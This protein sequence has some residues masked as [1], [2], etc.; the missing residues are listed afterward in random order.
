[1][2]AADAGD[3][4]TRTSEPT[5][6][7]AH[8]A[9]LARDAALVRAYRDGRHGAAVSS[10]PDVPPEQAAR[11]ILSGLRNDPGWADQVPS[12]DDVVAGLTALF[13]GWQD[14]LDPRLRSLVEQIEAALPVA[15][16]GPPAG[17][18]VVATLR[19]T[20]FFFAR[21]LE[22]PEIEHAYLVVM[23]ERF[24]HYTDLISR[25]V[26]STVPADILYRSYDPDEV[27]DFVRARV[28]ASPDRTVGAFADAALSLALN[29]NDVRARMLPV[30][31]DRRIMT[32]FLWDAVDLFVLGH[33]CAH[34]ELSHYGPLRPALAR[35]GAKHTRDRFWQE[36]QA[37]ELGLSL[38]AWSLRTS[39]A[40]GTGVSSLGAWMYFAAWEGF[41]LSAAILAAGT[42]AGG[43]R[44]L[45]R[46]RAVQDL[47]AYPP[48]HERK[49][50]SLRTV[51]ATG[52]ADSAT[53]SSRWASF[54]IALAHLLDHTAAEAEIAAQKVGAPAVPVLSPTTTHGP[55]A[56]A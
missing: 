9:S 28:R 32:S 5:Q 39:R 18:P 55:E 35:L 42:R 25:A 34:F 22:F 36:L 44:D 41:E 13:S 12:E 43:E 27:E 30:E 54:D 38:S 7:Q 23:H 53:P 31:P 20:P 2:R 51:E 3:G 49:A 19:S 8:E 14:G 4:E 45:A 50:Q 11:G 1:V 6:A 26:A 46:R 47:D 33:E 29:R 16:G 21:E 17:R 56:Q 15:L 37:D 24:T 10:A 48:L 52:A 40:A